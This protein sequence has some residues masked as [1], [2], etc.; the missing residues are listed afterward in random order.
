MFFGLLDFI[1]V[2]GWRGQR[3]VGGGRHRVTRTLEWVSFWGEWET[4]I[5]RVLMMMMMEARG[6][7]L[8]SFCVLEGRLRVLRLIWG[9]SRSNV[10]WR[11]NTVDESKSGDGK[12]RLQKSRFVL[13]S[14]RSLC[15]SLSHKYVLN[16][17]SNK[18]RKQ[19]PYCF[20]WWGRSDTDT[21][22]QRSAVD[23]WRGPGFSCVSSCRP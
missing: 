17:L 23:Q 6:Q 2:H 22:G 8:M 21:P 9:A 5:N 12:K 19:L 16:A 15:V 14:Y 13:S 11:W 20:H 4:E 18:M 7:F 1:V 3:A 10:K